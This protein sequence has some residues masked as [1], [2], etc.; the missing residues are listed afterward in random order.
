MTVVA[1]LPAPHPPALAYL[2]DPVLEAL[3][4]REEPGALHR[5]EILSYVPHFVPAQLRGRN[6]ELDHG[7]GEL[8]HTVLIGG[9]TGS[10]LSVQCLTQLLMTILK[11]TMPRT[12]LLAGGP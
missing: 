8:G 9:H 3:P 1:I 6:A 12:E 5:I 4:H 2:L 11:L 7:I 10:E